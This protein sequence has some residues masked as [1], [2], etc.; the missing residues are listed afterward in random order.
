MWTMMTIVIEVKTRIIHCLRLCSKDLFSSSRTGFRVSNFRTIDS[1]I[2]WVMLWRS[3]NFYV[4]YLLVIHFY[5]CWLP[6]KTMV[7]SNV[8]IQWWF[9]L[10]STVAV[11][12]V[13]KVKAMMVFMVNCEMGYCQIWLNTTILHYISMYNMIMKQY[14]VFIYFD[15]SWK[16]Y[17]V[18]Y[19]SLNSLINIYI[20]LLYITVLVDNEYQSYTLQ[21]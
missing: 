15:R 17:I 3:I 10:C 6:F 20:W 8:V 4:S 13:G 16:H 18:T 2:T 1:L 14:S 7:L 11:V 5:L 12:L 19:Y 21:D 9:I